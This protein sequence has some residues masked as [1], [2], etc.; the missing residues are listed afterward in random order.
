MS[1]TLPSFYVIVYDG[2]VHSLS[3]APSVQ[4][5]C[6]QLWVHT[7][8]THLRSRRLKNAGWCDLLAQSDSRP[9]SEYARSLFRG[10]FGGRDETS[11]SKL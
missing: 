9:P 3:H 5:K 7:C 2:Q 8:F 4:S 6:L 10:R 11:D 1:F